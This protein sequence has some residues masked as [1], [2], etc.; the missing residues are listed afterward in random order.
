MANIEEL[1]RKVLHGLERCSTEPE[2]NEECGDC[3]YRK[4]DDDFC[5]AR[6]ER[7]A[8]R[9]ILHLDKLVQHMEDEKR[10]GGGRP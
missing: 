6:L 3:P 2:T 7:D 8:R 1:T 5:I 4:V 10:P 9:V